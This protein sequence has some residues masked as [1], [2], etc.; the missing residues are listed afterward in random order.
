M[1]LWQMW[2]VWAAAAVALVI[3]E[4]L[5]PGYV[6]LGF[7]IGAGV[8]SLLTATGAD[9]GLEVLLLIFAVVSLIA[10]IAMRKIFGQPGDEAR[11]IDHDIND[12]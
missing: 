8:V 1:M 3:L 6:L 12:N 5:L 11:R 4:T 9:L 10:W 2:W 7:G